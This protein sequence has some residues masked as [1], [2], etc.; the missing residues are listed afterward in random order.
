MNGTAVETVE[1]EVL[2]PE[3]KQ[4][5]DVELAPYRQGSLVERKPITNDA[6]EMVNVVVVAQRKRDYKE[7][8]EIRDRLVRPYNTI[9]K[10]IN[11]AFKVETEKAD[12]DWRLRDQDL[13]AYRTAKQAAIDAANRKAIADAEE[14]RRAKEAKEEA[15]RQE[16]KRLRDE[17]ERLEQ[18][19][20]NRQFQEEMDKLAAAKKIKDDEEALARAKREG[21][22][23]AAREAQEMLDRAKKL[24]DER[25]QKAENDRLSSIA[26]QARLEKAA[27]KQ[28]AKADI[29][30]SEATMI[31][32]TIQVNDSLGKKT[33][34]D[35]SSVGTRQ[36][37][38]WRFDNGLQIYSDPLTR[39]KYADLYADDPRLA[40]VEIPK[41]C[42]LVDLSKLGKIVKSGMPVKGC[43]KFMRSATTADKK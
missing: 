26:E 4:K 37:E 32:P 1:T 41:S 6:Q 21:D 20:I 11:A 40:N 31:A 8:E 38:D 2:P 42:L 14:A 9:V 5:I 18:E 28:D 7:L 27:I 10:Q 22:A 19:E 30:A 36:V 12:T 25:A 15:A 24:E 23:R 33:L 39:K 16:A 43:T 35:G 3:I 34:S 29:A 13:S 17:Q